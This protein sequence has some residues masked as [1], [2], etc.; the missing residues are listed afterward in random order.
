VYTTFESSTFFRVNKIP[1]IPAHTPVL[2]WNHIPADT[3][4][5]SGGIADERHKYGTFRH[6][7]ST[8]KSF[9]RFGLSL[10]SSG[11]VERAAVFYK[12]KTYQILKI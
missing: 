11:L 2:T 4:V 8:S 5:E 10:E 6:F 3:P 7:R 12:N 9:C 1:A